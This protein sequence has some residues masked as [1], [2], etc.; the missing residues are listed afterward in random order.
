V[1]VSTTL[2]RIGSSLQ[3]LRPRPASRVS[4]P[5][6]RRNGHRARKHAIGVGDY[7]FDSHP[8]QRFACRSGKDPRCVGAKPPWLKAGETE[9]RPFAWSE[10]N[11]QQGT[12]PYAI[13]YWVL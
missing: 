9:T 4:W 8:T 13:P 1:S 12:R 6:R 3:T 2:H 10:G 7:T 5:L 11:V